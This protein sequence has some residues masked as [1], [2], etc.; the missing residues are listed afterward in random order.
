MLI[1]MLINHEAAIAFDWT[2]SSQIHED[3]SPPIVIKTVEHEAWQ[4]PSFPVPRALLPVVL[5]I[6]RDRLKKRVLEFCEGPYRNPWFLAAKKAPGTYR[7]INAAMKLNS[8]TLRD[9]NLPPSVDEFSEEFAGCAVASLI[10]FFSGYDQLV[11]APECRDMT[12]FMTPLGLLRMTTPPQGA[13]NSVAQFVRVVMRILDDLF[14]NIAMPFLDDIG[15]KGPYT[16]YDDEETLPGIRRYVYE[17]IQNLDKTMDRI[18][19]AGACI[20]AKSQFCH[21][22]MNIVG[23]VCGYNGRTPSTSK[24][25]KILEWPACKNVTEGKAFIGVCVYYRIWIKDFAMVAAPVYQLFRKNVKWNWGAEQ[26]QA[27]DTLK[28][29]LTTAPALCKIQYGPGWGEIYVGV[30]ASLDGW[31]GVMGQFDE[32]KKRKVSR[33]ES[34][35]WNKAE[36]N[37]DAT[38]REC[39]GVLKCLQRLRYW[40]YGVHF[41]LETDTKVLVAQ[42]NRAA[43]DLPGALVTRWI[44]WIRT[45]DFEVRHVKGKTHTAADGLSRRPRTESDDLDE[46]YEGDIDDWITAELDYLGISASSVEEEKKGETSKDPL[47]EEYSER[48]QNLARFLTTLKKPVSMSRIEFRALK[49]EAVRY[50]VRNRQLWRNRTKAFPPRLVVDSDKQRTELLESLHS[51]I[52]HRGRESTYS[53]LSARYF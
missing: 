48:S 2:G 40:L 43:T 28:T 26:Q 50:S 31:G 34:G 16:T 52:G 19:R 3:V 21:N 24:V 30:D 17:H 53:R 10:D 25:I 9:A 47:G 42:L 32:N 15:V 38:K 7:L 35:I 18:E 33:Y 12:A 39:R 22:G 46:Q 23:F 6:L 1:E 5:E 4:E 29:A 37:Y 13:T 44:A 27:M 36:R 20:G 11:L 51:E 14:P 49:K 8:V 41:I 45:F